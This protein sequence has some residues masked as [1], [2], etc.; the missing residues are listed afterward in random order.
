METMSDDK[1]ALASLDVYL[2]HICKKHLI[3]AMN[4]GEQD[5]DLILFRLN[6]QIAEQV[7]ERAQAN[8]GTILD[9]ATELMKVEIAKSKTKTNTS[10]DSEGVGGQV[11]KQ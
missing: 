2:S 11:P 3:Q 5:T 8:F 9:Q 1:I 7:K 10:K 6:K 4:N